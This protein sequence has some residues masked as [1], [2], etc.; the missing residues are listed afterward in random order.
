MSR[1]NTPFSEAGQDGYLPAYREGGE[2]FERRPGFYAGED[3]PTF[4]S[5]FDQDALDDLGFGLRDERIAPANSRAASGTATPVDGHSPEIDFGGYVFDRNHA[6]PIP[7]GLDRGTNA[8]PH[9]TTPYALYHE[10]AERPLPYRSGTN[11][12]TSYAP[13]AVQN[14]NRTHPPHRRSWSQNDIERLPDLAPQPYRAGIRHQPPYPHQNAQTIANPTFVRLCETR[15]SRPPTKI[16]SDGKKTS[17]YTQQ[18]RTGHHSRTNMPTSMPVDIDVSLRS[19]NR[20]VPSSGNLQLIGLPELVHMSHVDQRKT[21][22]KIIEVG[23][24][25]VL[26]MSMASTKGKA[27]SID[28]R[29]LLMGYEEQVREK[30]G[31]PSPEAVGERDEPRVREKMMRE[32]GKM[33]TLLKEGRDGEQEK[34]ALRGCEMIREVLGKMGD[35]DGGRGKERYDAKHVFGGAVPDEKFS[36][37]DN[38]Q[39]DVKIEASAPAASDEDSPLTDKEL[40]RGLVGDCSSP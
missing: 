35:G 12:N 25:A 28:P 4:A 13:S 7:D 2:Q 11:T 30:S 39:A 6:Y 38:H 29:L 24:M 32:L 22:Q 26:N 36:R 9:L 15:H 27:E 21:S 31:A 33:E 8:Y 14:F 37:E 1:E 34:K 17:R 16:P 40:I 23:A 19:E 18:T 5:T 10:T 20:A 3:S